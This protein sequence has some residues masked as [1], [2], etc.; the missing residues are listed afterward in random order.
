MPVTGRDLSFS[1]RDRPIFAGLDFDLAEARMTGLVG[2]SGSGKSTL[3]ALLVGLL[4]PDGGTISFPPELLHRGTVDRRKIGWI[5]QTANVL[6]RRSAVDNVALPARL[7]GVDPAE[8]RARAMVA[9][10]AVGLAERAGDRVRRLSGGQRQRVA[11][12]R[13]IA[14]D[15]PLLIADEPTVALDHVNRSLLVEALRAAAGMGAIVV[16]ATH[17]E[18][19]A[20]ACDALITLR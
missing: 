15:A 3:I 16:V 14:S 9:L 10:A 11:V 7:R 17:D 1:Y 20:E 5:M 18:S 2:P 4:E 6:G 19:V 13:A 12:A 8:T